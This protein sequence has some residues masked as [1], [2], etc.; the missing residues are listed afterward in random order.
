MS[1][2][3]KEF[4]LLF[5]ILCGLIGSL[6]AAP[7]EAD[8]VAQYLEAKHCPFLKEKWNKVVEYAK[9]HLP[10]TG[11]LKAKSDGYVYLKVD[12]NYIFSLFP[13]LSLQNSGYS[14]PPYFRAPDSPGAHINVFLADEHVQPIEIG[15]SFSFKLKKIVLVNPTKTTTFAILEVEAPQLEQLRQ[16]YGQTPKL[17]GHQFHIS[18]ARKEL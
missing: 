14:E 1:S 7:T 16:K 13:M 8:R 15:S 17:H 6:T 9:V 12:D 11:T 2:A 3:M 4:N 18:L 5:I 10:Q